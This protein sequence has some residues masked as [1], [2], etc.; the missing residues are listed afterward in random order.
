MVIS[1]PAV[2]VPRSSANIFESQAVFT[3]SAPIRFAGTS[4]AVTSR[5][6]NKNAPFSNFSLIDQSAEFSLSFTIRFFIN[7]PLRGS[8]VI[9]ASPK[10]PSTLKLSM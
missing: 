5:S 8:T 2:N 3:N 10:S 6:P 1:S 4:I 9:T 7:L